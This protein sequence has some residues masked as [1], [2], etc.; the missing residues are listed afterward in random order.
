[1]LNSLAGLSGA[2]VLLL[3]ACWLAR[4][5]LVAQ[6]AQ[7]LPL[8]G[9]FRLT[10]NVLSK[11]GQLA[12][13]TLV[14]F[15][16]AIYALGPI[17][18]R[19]AILLVLLSAAWCVTV[20]FGPRMGNLGVDS[21]RELM[22]ANSTEAR[23]FVALFVLTPGYRGRDIALT[24]LPI[25]AMLALSGAL[26]TMRQHPSFRLLGT[27]L[28]TLLGLTLAASLA[29]Y[30]RA[31]WDDIATS[32]TFSL[33]ATQLAK[34]LPPHSDPPINVV[35]YIGESTSALHQS[36][37]GYPRQTNSPLLPWER[38]LIVFRDVMSVHS[39]TREVL[40]RALTVAGDPM[41]DQLVADRDLKRAN[42]IELLNQSGVQTHWLSNQSRAGSWDFAS[43]LFGKAA[44]YSRFLNFEVANTTL[45]ERR[46]DHELLPMLQASLDRAAGRNLF[47]VHG[48]AGHH[49]YCRNIPKQAWM[50]F[51]DAQTRVPWEGLFGLMQKRDPQEHRRSV[52]CYDSAM[53]YVSDNISK[54]LGM[55]S[56][57]AA[58]TVFFYFAD[59]GEDPLGGTSHDAALPRLAHLAVPLFL[60]ANTAAK[61]VMADK[62]SAAQNNAGKPYSIGWMSD[63]LLDA[64]GIQLPSRQMQSL[65]SERLQ[66]MPRYALVRQ[67]L[68]RGKS[69]VSLDT[70][71][72]SRRDRSDDVMKL[73]RLNRSLDTASQQRLC[74]HRNDSLY[75]FMTSSYIA[76]CVEVDLSIDVARGTVHAYHPPRADNG[77]SLRYLLESSGPKLRRV[78][79][80]VKNSDPR[81]LALLHEELKHA[82]E[83]HPQLDF[84]V[85]VEPGMSVQPALI[86][87]LR[88]LRALGRITTSLYLPAALSDVCGSRADTPD[89]I[90]A[91][92]KIDNALEAGKFEGV[93]FDTKLLMLARR[94]SNYER[95]M[96]HV[97]GD[98]PRPNPRDS[99]FTTVLVPVETDFD[100]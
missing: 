32:K 51:D 47:V 44:T 46:F 37:M 55:V 80:D 68:F 36:L 97:W 70:L 3:L 27:A 45:D 61:S 30:V 19:R 71:D 57:Q 58:P 21:L 48:Y 33:E 53:H 76:G 73:A 96:R 94:L 86:M 42:L 7:P 93:S 72:P 12:V 6:L 66:V 84:I 8:Q 24:L 39:F 74:V 50:H 65:L 14:A 10:L 17:T 90:N 56:A 41:G 34:L 89:C 91:L 98:V 49:D 29:W 75:K 11:L 81:A 15:T 60:Y 13:P 67:E 63:T 5:A 22:G 40:M 79:L 99:E 25:L 28:S 43:Q 88:E 1:M 95:L 92:A 16:F 85:E 20:T 59:H 83:R 54:V 31:Q 87:R 26:P 100:Y 52:D 2:I 78:W 69:H 77:L 38:D 82:R 4:D 35:L 9:S 62:L 23:E 18:R 64:L